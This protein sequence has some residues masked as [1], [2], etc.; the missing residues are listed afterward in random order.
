MKKAIWGGMILGSLV[1]GW[2]PTWFGGDAFSFAGLIGSTIGA[3][4]GIFLGYW[5]GQRMA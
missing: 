4:A 5:V 3:L 1:G 2:S